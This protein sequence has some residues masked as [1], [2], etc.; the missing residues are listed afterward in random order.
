MT[1]AIAMTGGLETVA[2]R[3]ETE[4]PGTVVGVV[5]RALVVA[6]S[7]LRS[8]VRTVARSAVALTT[9]TEILAV[10]KLPPLL[11]L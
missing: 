7:H 5:G 11:Q 6:S 3:A 9:E 2:M 4:T 1:T 10:K 8:V